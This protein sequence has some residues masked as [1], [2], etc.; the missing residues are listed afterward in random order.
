MVQTQVNNPQKSETEEVY[1]TINLVYD[2]QNYFLE[3]FR[4]HNY[5]NPNL[6][7]VVDIPDD[8]DSFIVMVPKGRYLVRAVYHPIGITPAPMVHIIM[9]YVTVDS[10]LLLT[11]DTSKAVNRITFKPLLPDG[12]P[13]VA[14]M[15]DMNLNMVEEGN[16]FAN[17]YVS[18]FL[19][20]EN[21][22]IIHTT[23]GSTGRVYNNG[24]VIDYDP[25]FDILIN[26]VS[27]KITCSTVRIMDSKEGKQIITDMGSYAD[28]SYT[29]SNNPED[30][31]ECINQ[32]NPSVNNV[33]D[34][35]FPTYGINYIFGYNQ[36]LRWNIMLQSRNITSSESYVGLSDLRQFTR[37]TSPF[38]VFRFNEVM[39]ESDFINP[40]KGI[41]STPYSNVDDYFSIYNYSSGNYLVDLFSLNPEA[42]SFNINGINPIYSH[43]ATLGTTDYGNTVPFVSFMP[44]IS[45]SGSLPEGFSSNIDFG[46]IGMNGEYRGSDLYAASLDVKYS[47]STVFE[48]MPEVGSW[49]WGW[50]GENANRGLYDIYITDENVKFDDMQGRNETHIHFDTQNDSD[51]LP[52]LLMWM[53]YQDSNDFVTNS[54]QNK[55]GSRLLFSAG[56]FDFHCNENWNQ[57]FTCR[58]EQPEVIVEYAPHGNT[59]FTPLSVVERPEDFFMPGFGFQYEVALEQIARKSEGG[60]FDL[61]ITLS[62]VAGNNQSQLMAPAFRIEEQ[63]G[64]ESVSD[65]VENIRI[66]GNTI[67]APEGA[68]IYGT[69]GIRTDGINVRPGIYIVRYS[70]R[71]IKVRVK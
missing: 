3:A 26:P 29:I 17:P 36:E 39:D 7:L 57:W 53:Q 19:C 10:E 67:V 69:D 64:V 32:I 16:I 45:Y 60:W 55:E 54:I 9:E 50:F 44:C 38:C 59:E 15:E 40:F 12:Q 51:C 34:K 52:P 21:F 13:A 46:F 48:S 27:N 56:D 63:A 37:N 28:N 5:D 71:A 25:C 20:E 18:T 31:K 30:Y 47:G 70:D 65:M 14:D 8:E 41:Y 6:N 23:I 33:E 49:S 62:D 11:F 35:N 2:K 61:R 42:V 66:E 1:V 24:E 68:L 58:E 4:F 43:S 22:G